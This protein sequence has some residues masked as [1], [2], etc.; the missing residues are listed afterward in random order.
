M[1]YLEK[2]EKVRYF[3]SCS[4]ILGEEVGEAA[5][6]ANVLFLKNHGVIVLDDSVE[7]AMMRLETLEF[8]CR[9]MVMVKGSGIPLS[10]LTDEV[11][12]EFLANRGIRG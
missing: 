3:H 7:E 2:I 8:T 12:E 1:Y 4:A 5:K 10:V 6:K 9:M 11:A